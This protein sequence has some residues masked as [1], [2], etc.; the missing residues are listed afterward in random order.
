MGDVPFVIALAMVQSGWGSVWFGTWVG[1]T[2]ASP[3]LFDATAVSTPLS[4]ADFGEKNLVRAK[5][6]AS[7]SNT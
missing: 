2:V 3:Q 7:P 4:T 5:T 1:S 6:S